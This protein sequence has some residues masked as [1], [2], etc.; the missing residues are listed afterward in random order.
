[1]GYCISSDK[2]HK[3]KLE[4]RYYLFGRKSLVEVG[5]ETAWGVLGSQSVSL[6]KWLF[7]VDFLRK[8]F[9]EVSFSRA[10]AEG[11]GVC[12]MC[13]CGCPPPGGAQS[14][15]FISGCGGVGRKIAPRSYVGGGGGAALS[16]SK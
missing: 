15:D 10:R 16:Q 2:I 11:K 7:F 13:C 12:V 3:K 6:G 5:G 14:C 9:E 8:R 1:M 4:S